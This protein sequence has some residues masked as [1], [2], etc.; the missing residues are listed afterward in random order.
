MAYAN[1]RAC[2]EAAGR[3]VACMLKGRPGDWGMDIDSWDWNPGVSLI[4]LLDHAE[5]TRNSE[6]LEEVIRWTERNRLRAD[7]HRAVNAMAPFAIYPG[8]YERTGDSYFMQHAVEIGDWML[9]EAPRT[10]IG[11]FEHTVTES[12]EFAEQVWADTVF[13][14]V[15]FLAR[16]AR[17]TANKKYGEEALL[18]LRLHYRLL[19]DEETGVLFHGWD[20]ARN[21]PM[22]AARW[23]RANAWIA[24]AT[25]WILE[26]LDGMA[27]ASKEAA[28]FLV[29]R[30]RVLLQGLKSCQSENGL[31]PVVVNRPE[32]RPEMS[33]S[34]GIACG[35][36]K[37]AKLGW[38]GADYR[39]AADLTLE[40]LLGAIDVD[41]C[42][43]G[44]SGGTPVL[45]TEE[46]YNAFEVRPTLYGQGLAL[47]L[48]NEYLRGQE[49]M[50]M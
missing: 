30:C 31:W 47:L 37:A 40:R 32:F 34:A 8:L 20:C 43:G 7:R 33:G 24:L 6:L 3:I 11:A 21:N 5:C 14:A 10:K 16:L 15:L 45:P 9:T 23:G 49:V 27:V 29:E 38:V 39:A 2:E 19:Q 36:V 50:K 4:A 35:F 26:E 13:M 41:G 46:A 44:V 48:L 18:Q 42:V 1:K 12:E 17:A 28:A 25:P 22:S